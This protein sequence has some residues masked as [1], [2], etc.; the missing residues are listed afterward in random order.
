M[1][2]V[3][4]GEGRGGWILFFSTEDNF[5]D[6]FYTASIKTHRLLISPIIKFKVDFERAALVTVENQEVS[7]T[8]IFGLE[9]KV[10][11]ESLMY[12]SSIV[13]EIIKIISIF[14][15]NSRQMIFPL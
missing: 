2:N 12:G 3:I 5:M 7:S 9:Y 4:G 8:K 1:L 14:V 6:G 15:R 11:V 10:S 13:N